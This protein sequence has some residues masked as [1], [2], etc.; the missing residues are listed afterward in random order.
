MEID[1]TKCNTVNI[2]DSCSVWNIISSE[3]LYSIIE[4]TFYFSITGFVEY[5]CLFKS[6]NS[7]SNID[8]EIRNRLIKYRSKTK[9]SS[10]T[11]TIEDLQSD[12]ILNSNIKLGIGE[13]SSIAF[14]KKTNQV[15]LTDDQNA[16]K[17][18]KDILGKE[19]V[20]TVPHIFGWL[21][22]KGF[23][24]DSDL[25]P[26]IVQHNYFNRPLEPYFRKV[27]LEALRIRCLFNPVN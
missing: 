4:D 13:L 1:I 7:I 19:R 26:I 22:Y 15:F 14:C 17:I 10:H 11:L 12:E 20:Q 8:N 24:T 18:A 27:Y 23:L 5:E 21:Y 2:T 25:E 3:I 9:F 6:R 16:R